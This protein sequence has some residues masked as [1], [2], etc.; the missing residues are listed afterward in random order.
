MIRLPPVNP[1]P[2]TQWKRN[3]LAVSASAALFG[4]GFTLV[5]PFL[6][7]YV[8]ELGIHSKTSTAMWCGVLL[9]ITPLVASLVGP[10]WG[11][12]AD[13]YGL[14]IMAIRISVVSLLIWLLMGFA[15]D[16]YDLFVLRILSGVFGGFGSLSV[17][18]ATHWCPNNRVSRAIGSLQAT[19]TFSMALGPFVGGMLAIW[20]GIRN[21]FFVTA[22]LSLLTLLLFFLLYRDKP[23]HQIRRLDP[24]NH[25]FKSG[26]SGLLRLPN[27]KVF[28]LLLLTLTV[29]D[30]TFALTIPLFITSIS[31][32]PVEVARVAGL[33]LSLAAF[34]ESFSSWYAGRKVISAPPH[35]LLL[36]RFSFGL[37]IC[38]TLTFAK[39]SLDLLILRLLLAFLAGGTL[40]ITYSLANRVIPSGQRA[41]TF[42]LLSSFAMLGHAFGPLVGGGI[43]FFCLHWVF[44]GNAF[45][46]I[47]LFCLVYQTVRE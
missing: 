1:I 30:R 31:N 47:G 8:K 6:P 11:R 20:I 16:V 42:A 37:I 24:V 10:F 45:L 21:T 27:L 13:R 26:L 43:A 18:L 34:A 4:A 15:R 32:D 3:L 33:I 19:Q 5:M 25:Q 23:V 7:I 41:S 9:G 22:A 35:Q 29:I 38:F 17:S 28:S 2:N 40:T 12:I 14:K 39:S 36:L 44:L 46:Y